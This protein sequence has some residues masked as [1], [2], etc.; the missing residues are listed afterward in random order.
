[1]T[2]ELRQTKMQLLNG[3]KVVALCLIC[4]FLKCTGIEVSRMKTF[5]DLKSDI[6]ALPHREYI[7]LTHWLSERDWQA[8]DEEIERDS[9]AGRLDFLIEEALDEKKAGSLRNL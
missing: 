3:G 9:A 1:M 6:E 5:E 8:W 7:R 2:F 4:S